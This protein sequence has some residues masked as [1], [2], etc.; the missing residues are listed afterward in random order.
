VAERGWDRH[1][2]SYAASLIDTSGIPG[3]AVAQAQ[4]GE[5]I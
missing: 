2:E 4:G 1:Y 3:A 5:V